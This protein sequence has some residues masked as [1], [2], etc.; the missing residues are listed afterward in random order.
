MS[1]YDKNQLN[2]VQLQAVNTTEGAVLVTAGAGSGKT[3]LLTHR[4]AHLI[5]SGVS[6]YNILAITFT[7]KA[8]NEMKE[9]LDA[10]GCRD[11]WIS[12]FHVMCLRFLRR[13]GES[14]GIKRNFTIYAESEMQSVVKRICKELELEKDFYKTALKEI[15]RAKTAAIAPDDYLAVCRHA[16]QDAE[17]ISKVYSAYNK[18][19][20]EC[21]ALDFDDMLL[22]AYELLCKD[23]VAREY[24]SEKF[25]YIH[26]D[27]FQDTNDLQYKIVKIL[28]EKHNNV[29]VVGDEDQS[30]YSWRGASVGNIFDFQKDFKCTVF[31][32]EQNYRS[33]KGIL[34]IANKIIK[35]N[36]Q[37]LDKRLWTQNGEGNKV[38]VYQAVSEGNEADYV[39]RTVC[40]LVHSKKYGYNDIA[41]LMRLNASTRPFEERF[42][43]YGVP[44]RIYGGF[45][46]YDRKEI[47]DVLAYL[48]LVSNPEDD[49]AFIRIVNFRKRG[50]GAT[51]L[52]QLANYCK[53]NG[54]SLCDGVCNLDTD[55]FPKKLTEKFL[56]L[57]NEL[58]IL[59]EVAQQGDA[60]ALTTFI[61]DD[62]IK[63]D[64]MFVGD[65]DE[66]LGKIANLR[67]LQRATQE[68]CVQNPTATLSDYL[69]TVCLYSDT[70][71]MSDRDNSVTVATV[72]STKGLEFKVVFVVALE[73]SIFP[74]VKSTDFDS[75]RIE[76][77]RRLMYVAVTRAKERLFL[78]YAQSRF[79]YGERKH[80]AP[81][82][83]LYEAGLLEQSDNYE[84]SYDDSYLEIGKTSVVR[85]L[86][87]QEQPVKN[88]TETANVARVGAVV[89]HVRFGRGVIEKIEKQAACTYATI[90]FDKIGVLML[91]LDFA[92]IKI[93]EE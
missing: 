75:A 92:P 34:D 78:T 24:Y 55:A 10:M 65:D 35:H 69:Q 70:D 1:T 37:R 36:S 16:P 61:L 82:R 28:A 54:V 3:R 63:I 15:S 38:T 18:V 68:F 73:E 57:G 11:V 43:Q 53:L 80:N 60:Y 45:K 86:L 49:E 71:T 77:E 21:N 84:R 64:E 19:L 66:S 25:R 51:S 87:K 41:V 93:C 48:R 14:I 12:T 50:I 6:P 40:E 2:D 7:N 30:I 13:F 91:A 59:Q 89:E 62:L 9:R 33:C 46:F 81:S 5:E 56:Q 72:H 32:L 26:V 31:K 27:E 74:I 90:R 58:S 23:K 20:R 42:M 88:N 22:R 76:E 67:E 29:F 17:D 4:I 8:A 83:F 79:V 47:K 39:V 52:A 85:P 44:H